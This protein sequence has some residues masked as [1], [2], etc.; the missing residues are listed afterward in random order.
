MNTPI[1]E[2]LLPLVQEYARKKARMW[3]QGEEELSKPDDDLT[4]FLSTHGVDW[5][6]LPVKEQ[7]E[8]RDQ[9]ILAVQVALQPVGSDC[10]DSPGMHGPGTTAKRMGIGA[11]SSPTTVSLA[12]SG[13]RQPE[14]VKCAVEALEFVAD[15]QPDVENGTYYW[16]DSVRAFRKAARKALSRLRS[17][18]R[19][20]VLG[21][22]E[23]IRI[24]ASG[25]ASSGA[26]AL[27]VGCKCRNCGCLH[28]WKRRIETHF[29]TV[30]PQCGDMMYDEVF[31]K[32]TKTPDHSA[33]LVEARDALELVKE[34]FGDDSH[35]RLKPAV[36]EVVDQSLSKLQSIK[37]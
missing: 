28:E 20:P 11:V 21:G 15:G 29:S 35:L 32:Q 27:P 24:P 6:L 26:D 36:W 34:Q 14:A 13:V 23:A 10:V 16:E 7:D 1:L 2:T 33:L 5:D 17:S 9:Y 8:I 31:L 12:E 18:L 25:L 19:E 4:T 30:C 37:L 22:P 3:I